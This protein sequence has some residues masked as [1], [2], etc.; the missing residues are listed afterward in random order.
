MGGIEIVLTPRTRD[1]GNDFQV[2]RVL[3]AGER[4]SVGSF[5][6]F[7]QMGPTVLKPGR[8]L[9]VRPH[10]HIGLATV[11]YLF[12]GEILHKD[13]LGTVQVIRPGAVNW[14]T[15]GSG[16]VHSER[17][18]L[19]SRK[20]GASLFGIQ[21][22]VALPQAN[23]EAAPAFAHYDAAALPVIEDR[24]IRIR[25]IV[26]T[27]F[28]RRAPVTVFSEM[29]YADAVLDAGARLELSAEHEE[30]ALYVVEGR[31]AVDGTCVEAAQMAVLQPGAI[32]ILTT[33]RAS[34]L[35]VMG[36]APLDGPRHLWWNFVSS[37]C[38]RI[39]QAKDDWRQ[40]RFAPVP[41]EMEAIPLPE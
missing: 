14:M 27:L 34:R 15:A 32:V 1:L 17:T 7:D 25:L 4:C 41:G 23:E 35:L 29:F 6:F 3:P 20:G 39:E 11:T 2:R 13:S 8:G 24:G 33:D 31:I 37:S 40:G 9:D 12:D 21:T 5:V 16:I 28:G 36:G 22:W 19:E 30:R 18:P 26:G 38:E 10:P